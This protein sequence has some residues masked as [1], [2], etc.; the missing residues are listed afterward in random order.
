MKN[1]LTRLFKADN[2]NRS[3]I[4]SELNEFINYFHQFR[5]HSSW[6]GNLEEK[7]TFIL[8]KDYQEQIIFIPGLILL[9]ERA[10]D[11]SPKANRFRQT[12]REEIRRKFPTLT[13][14]E[15]FKIIFETA[16]YQERSMSLLMLSHVH[17]D[18]KELMGTTK[19]SLFDNFINKANQAF[20]LA[21]ADVLSR[22]DLQNT[23]K[24]EVSVIY[25]SLFKPLGDKKVK[26]LFQTSYTLLGEIYSLLPSFSFIVSILP[27]SLLTEQ[28]LS[29]L[30]RAQIESVLIEKTAKL[31][32]ANERLRNEIKEKEKVQSALK[33]NADRLNRI[34]E[35]AMDAVVLMDGTGTIL[36]WN[37]Q[38][39]SIFK[40]KSEEVIGRP[41][42]ECIIPEDKR[43][44]H[45]RGLNYYLR[46]GKHKF[47]NSRI[48][49]S[50]ITKDGEI[51]PL[52]LS[53]VANR[54]EGEIIFTSFI[55]DISNRKRYEQELMSAKIK[56]EKASKSK[57]D[58]LSTMSHEI[59][60][61]MNGLSGTIEYLLAE[62]P[63]EDQIDSLKL[64]RHSSESLLVILND[65]LD[66]SKIEEGHVEFD[67]RE[68]SLKELCQHIVSTYIQRA[69]QKSIKLT[70]DLDDNCPD[71]LLGDPVRLSQILNNLVSNA[72]KFTLHGEVHLAVS[73]VKSNRESATYRFMVSDTGIGIAKGNIGKIF[74]RFT[75]V[76]DQSHNTLSGTGLGLSISKKL[77][78]LQG[79][80]L[81]AESEL[82]TGSRFYFE[83][84]FG[85]DKQHHEMQLIHETD[86]ENLAG[87][88]I[89]L[90]EDNR[91]NQIVAERFL[92]KWKCQ[93][94]FAD[95]G[96][97]ALDRVMENHYDLI[98]MDIQ[99][100]IMNG[101]QATEAIR[102]MPGIHLREVPIIALT[103]DVL[104]E[105]KEEAIRVGMNDLM[106][107]PFDSNK[108]YSMIINNIK[109]SNII[110]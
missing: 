71:Q 72:I 110:K 98:L 108:L 109:F 102:K 32:E 83:L 70:L 7:L 65:I 38:A 90:V 67:K 11:G 8:S 25:D 19:E 95:N 49:D 74:D 79:S 68:F 37:N 87:T 107:K 50:G 35:N 3:S 97:Q 34:I 105:V 103:A 31:E 15:H 29:L 5:T 88:K 20:E 44:E 21:Q 53:I 36:F 106:T 82:G 17:D 60:T 30:S 9:Y 56:A 81:T 41:L 42:A 28:Q 13:S 93:V 10:L 96:E 57:A 48:E 101:Y 2:S 47:L 39:E 62:N 4:R 40:W 45:E 80:N 1:L 91:I 24:H 76:H 6:N 104:P 73:L 18:C 51:I 59:R 99:M 77:L 12:F 86:T 16:L 33:D 55:R 84:V 27:E 63:R 61:P 14:Q 100:P 22:S 58:F 92:K 94:D 78:E 69:E 64:M 54:V 23:I 26:S 46:S 43:A 85:H 89:L 52:E 75:Q 66:L